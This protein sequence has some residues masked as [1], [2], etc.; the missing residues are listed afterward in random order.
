MAA[1]SDSESS[2]LSASDWRKIR[3]LVDC[4]VNYKESRK[5]SQLNRTI[6]KLSTR[7]TLVEQE[8]KKLQEAL[9]KERQRKQRS[10]L[11]PLKQSEDCHGGAVFWSPRKVR[12]ARNLQE[13]KD[14]DI[15][16]L[17]QQKAAAIQAQ[18]ELKLIKAR[19]IDA[20][21]QARAEARLLREKK[22]AD[23]VAERAARQA[24]RKAAKRLQQA[25]KTSQKGTKKSLKARIRPTPKTIVV[26]DQLS[27]RSTGPPPARS[28]R[29]RDIKLPTKYK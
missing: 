27:D 22:R 6:L 25:I 28:R 3:Q 17:Q 23:E 4:A 7:S 2:N 26:G 29:D 21:R 1:E 16:Q 12:E 9:I 15:E 11:K 14:R 19:E 20:R 8:N 18:E 24:A 13:Q 10:R 5:I